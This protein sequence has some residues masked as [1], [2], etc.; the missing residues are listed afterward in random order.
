ML[1]RT[2]QQRLRWVVWS[3]SRDNRPGGLVRLRKWETQTEGERE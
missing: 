3:V 1:N 2:G